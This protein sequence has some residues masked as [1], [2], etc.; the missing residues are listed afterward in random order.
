MKFGGKLWYENLSTFLYCAGWLLITFF[1]LF[2]ALTE[3]NPYIK[4]DIEKVN[5]KV[6]TLQRFPD[7]IIVAAE[8]INVE[9]I[10][11]QIKYL[12]PRP[13]MDP[14]YALFFF[15]LAIIIVI[16]FKDFSYKKPFTKKVLLGLQ[17]GFALLLVFYVV[18]FI[19]Y[20]WFSEQVKQLTNGMFT[21]EKP[22][23]LASPEFWILLVLLRLIKIYKNGVVLQSDAELTV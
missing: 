11:P 2:S 16:F 13:H 7:V 3:T 12:A 15:L 17:T 1:V 10:S 9:S 6:D 19:R 4:A 5:S 8:K 18:N 20:D 22:I 23:P 14:L 21:Y